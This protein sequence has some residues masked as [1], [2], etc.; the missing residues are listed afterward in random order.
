MRNTDTFF[1][2]THCDRCNTELVARI[3]SWFNSDCICISCSQKET[4]IKKVLKMRGEDPAD[5][6]GCGYIPKVEMR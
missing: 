3:M 6:E 1:I 5:Y 4:E 2:K